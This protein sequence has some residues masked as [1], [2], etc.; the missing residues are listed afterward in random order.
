MPQV[1]RAIIDER[2]ELAELLTG[3]DNAAWDAP[4]LCRG[5]RVREV[6]AHITVP[7]RLTGTRFA[8]EFVRAGEISTGSPTTPRAST[9]P[10]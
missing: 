3:F 8:V 4:T 10:R 7:F 1:R 2:A 9:P 5:W 6:V